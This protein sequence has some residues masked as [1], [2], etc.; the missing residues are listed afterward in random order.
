[1][2]DSSKVSSKQSIPIKAWIKKL[3]IDLRGQ[4]NE[5]RL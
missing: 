3:S 2:F 5:T 4:V 1:M